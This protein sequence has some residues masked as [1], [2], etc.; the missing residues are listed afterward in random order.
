MMTKFEMI[1]SLLSCFAS[2]GAILTSYIALKLSYQ[3]T[4]LNS[5]QFVPRLNI[6]FFD[7]GVGIENK[8]SN[9]FEIF[10]VNIVEIRCTGFC[11]FSTD[12]E[13]EMSFV[14]NSRSFGDYEHEIP[15]GKYKKLLYKDGDDS[16]SPQEIKQ[17]IFDGVYSYLSEN[18]NNDSKIGYAYPY[19][20]RSVYYIKVTYRNRFGDFNN[21]IM[22]RIPGSRGTGETRTI[23]SIEDYDT[24]LSNYDRRPDFESVEQVFNYFKEQSGLTLINEKTTCETLH[25]F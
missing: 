3:A 22:K 20:N 4:I 16:Y 23:L 14:T 2:I 19:F 24:E 7:N 9:L 25:Y 1:I 15:L 6:K 8:D 21:Y 13:V 11:D 18:Y 17:H 10:T 12:M 5:K